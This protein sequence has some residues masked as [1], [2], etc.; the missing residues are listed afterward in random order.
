MFSATTFAEVAPVEPDH[1]DVLARH[2]ALAA[3]IRDAA[4]ASDAIAAV[5]DWDAL[6]REIQTWEAMA[7]LRF[8]QA[9]GD[10]ERK[11]DADRSNERKPVYAARDAGFKRAVLASPHRAA[12][13]AAYGAHALAL[14]GCDVEAVDDRIVDRLAAEAALEDEYVALLGG[15]RI[16]FGE[17]TY[18]LP[19]IAAFGEDA[20]RS[21]RE[22]ATRAK[23]AYFDEHRDDLDRIYDGLVRERTAAARALG[24]ADFTELG[25]RRMRRTDYAAA[26]VARLRDEVVREIV[27]LCARIVESQARAIGVERLMPWDLE[28]YDAAE[29]LRPPA[30]DDLTS[31]GRAALAA[32]HPALGRF[33]EM[34]FAGGLHDLPIRDGKAGGGFCTSFST[35][36]LPFVY[37]NCNGTTHDVNVLVH[38]LGHAFQCRQSRDQPLAD[39]LWPTLEACEINS[40]GME[41]LVRPRLEAF[42]GDGAERYRRRHLAA[43]LMLLPYGCAVDHFQHLVYAAPDATPAERHAMW[44]RCETRYLPW[45]VAG[46][47]AHI[48]NGGAWQQQRHIYAFPFYYVDYVMAMS[49]ALQFWTASLDDA[50]DAIARYVALCGRGGEAPFQALARSAGLRS[51]FDGGVFADIA[52]RAD[53]AL[54]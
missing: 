23:W 49:C 51:P 38:E 24:Y 39:Y 6:R 10:P 14:W 9:T 41:F 15:A 40:M 28:V 20:D 46:G 47:I 16:P 37:A 1:E 2:D 11:A 21:V 27:P 53:A 32:T 13:E 12:I 3:R 5:R 52:A 50:D 43:S 33:A 45:R 8:H 18:S 17:T 7:S 54:F 29:R 42:F 36:G 30:G 19:G 35:Y 22:A 34:L 48:E 4:T 25:Y 44:R 31:A 26:D